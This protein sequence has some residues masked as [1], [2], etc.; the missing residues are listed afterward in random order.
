M[1]LVKGDSI[2]WADVGIV[3]VG[4]AR[5]DELGKLGCIVISEWVASVKM[6]WL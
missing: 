1:A 2:L 4:V 6:S 3:A 5:S